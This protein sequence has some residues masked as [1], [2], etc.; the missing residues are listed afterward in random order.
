[1]NNYEHLVHQRCK[2]DGSGEEVWVLGLQYHLPTPR[3]P[4]GR[5]WAHVDGDKISR[6]TVI[7]ADQLQLS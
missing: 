2:V 4:E 7:P 5:I 1:M 3:F 6:G